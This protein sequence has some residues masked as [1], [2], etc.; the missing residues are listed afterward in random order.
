MDQAPNEHRIELAKEKGHEVN[1][2][3]PEAGKSADTNKP[4]YFHWE[5]IN[6]YTPVAKEPF[7]TKYLP[8]NEKKPA[9]KPKHIVK[10]GE[11]SYI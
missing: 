9:P 8:M 1:G 6:V 4:I 3:V 2:S 11:A 5:N 10:N 7:Y